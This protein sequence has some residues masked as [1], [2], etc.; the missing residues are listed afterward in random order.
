MQIPSGQY[1]FITAS[2][3][4]AAGPIEENAGRPSNGNKNAQSTKTPLNFTPGG[5]TLEGD[6]N[7]PLIEPRAASSS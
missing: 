1:N 7:Q 4:R 5:T 6:I 3:Q 2:P